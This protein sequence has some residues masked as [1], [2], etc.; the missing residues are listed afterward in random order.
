[1]PA[2]AS[3]Y[4]KVEPVAEMR[5]PESASHMVKTRYLVLR[6][7]TDAPIV[8][9]VQ[10]SCPQL[11]K[12][13]PPAC[14]IK[15]RDFVGVKVSLDPTHY[16]APR[17]FSDH[18]I[19]VYCRPFNQLKAVKRPR[20]TERAQKLGLSVSKGIVPPA[21]VLELPGNAS[22]VE[23]VPYATLGVDDSG[24]TTAREIASETATGAEIV[25]NDFLMLVPDSQVGT[26][27]NIDDGARTARSINDPGCWM[28]DFLDSLFPGS[29]SLS[30]GICGGVN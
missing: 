1:M 16:K 21:T 24:T 8:A 3:D 10:P 23:S 6:N 15:A 5:F 28:F 9:K 22:L 18:S 25:D 2:K 29:G 27:Y 11:L 12:V 30:P 14:F 19:S 17:K 26:A 20:D 7:N 4:A 13:D